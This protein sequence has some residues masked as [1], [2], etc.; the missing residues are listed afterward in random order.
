MISKSQLIYKL[1]LQSKLLAKSFNLPT[2]FGYDLLAKSIY[3]HNDYDVLC[4]SISKLDYSTGSIYLPEYEKLKFLFICEVEDQEFI[5]ELHRKIEKMAL[6]LEEL[7]IINI[8]KNHTIS[9]IY[10][11]FGLENE[12]KYLIDA[13]NV[14]LNWQPCFDTLQD[15]LAVLS[16]NILI[17]EIPFRLIATKVQFDKSSLDDLKKSLKTNLVQIEESSIKIH[18]EKLLI[19]EHSKWLLDTSD[20]LSKIGSD[21]PDEHSCFYKINNQN[22]LIYG[23]PLSPHLQINSEDSCKKINIQI[24]D[25]EEKQV[26]IL[27]IESEKL[28]F[29]CI[30]LN[31]IE[32]GEKCYSPKNQW[33]QDTLLSRDDAFQF[34]IA[35]NKSYNFI[36]LRPFA[37]VD[38]LENLL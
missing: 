25:T 38:W 34:R 20:C 14:K 18:E 6:R 8:S 4:D 2:R 3:Q 21:N 31:K 30:F 37:N 1:E 24:K 28:I 16:S 35:L 19:D 5:S 13:E 17:N 12:S 11:L 26:F 32:E 22:Y 29:E 7:I 23:Y 33:I 10:K 36:I 9:N 15:Q 27:N